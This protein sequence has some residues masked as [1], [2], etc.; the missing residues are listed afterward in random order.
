MKSSQWR[1]ALRGVVVAVLNFVAVLVLW[2]SYQQQ[3]QEQMQAELQLRGE[4]I[5]EQIQSLVRENILSLDH[6]SKRIEFTQG[7][8]YK[9]WRS[10]AELLIQMHPSI[11]FVEVIDTSMIIQDVYPYE[12]NQNVVDL[13]LNTVD[14]RRDSWIENTADSN[15]NITSWKKMIQG[16]SAFLIDAPLYYNQ[17]F[18]GTV[19]A[20]FNFNQELTELISGLEKFH[21]E[22][23]D[24]EGTRFYDFPEKSEPKTVNFEAYEREITLHAESDKKWR[25]KITMIDAYV[26][27]EM[28]LVGQLG[29]SLGLLISFLVGIIVYYLGRLQKANARFREVNKNLIRTNYELK[30]E[31]L[32]AQRASRSKTDFI[33]TMSHEMRTPLNAILGFLSMLKQEKLSESG[34]DYL[35]MMDVSSRSLLSLINDILDIDKIE[36]GKVVLDEEPFSPT[37]ELADLI[38]TFQPE[39]KV[40]GLKLSTNFDA[41]DG[42][43]VV[44]DSGKYLQIF[45]NLIRN[46]FKFT[47]KGSVEVRYHE[48]V[49]DDQVRITVEI[50]DTGIGIPKDRLN[51]IFGRFSQLDSGKKRKYEGSGLGLTICKNLVSLMN[52]EISV[53]SELNKGST[54]KVVLNLDKADHEL[55][56]EDK[57]LVQR[58]TFEGSK[59]LVAEDNLL[60]Q[61]LLKKILSQMGIEVEVANDGIVAVEK[62]KSTIFDLILMDLHMPDM[63]GI[64]AAST[65]ISQGYQKPIVALTADVTRE[66]MTAA[67]SAGMKDYITKPIDQKKLLE[68]LNR[69]L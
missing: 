5:E 8:Y 12:T 45:T 52:G 20:G 48:A 50:E 16:G 62:A 51:E 29:L 60:N 33:S 64:E 57:E 24:D 2:Q 42:C 23:F 58:E 4:Y 68:V 54:F 66:S 22:L 34:K 15:L 38:Q 37:A 63:D 43:T 14:Y 47:D 41:N 36:S 46:S 25:L 3:Q 28:K 18:Q 49:K 65:L 6:L 17:K 27:P 32:V 26:S 53:E 13:D 30:N 67:K 44:G 7:E 55:K 61:V 10:D 9:N 35:R 19:T 40:K 31:R 69:Y 39:F 21:V 11:K 1:H 56:R 59:V